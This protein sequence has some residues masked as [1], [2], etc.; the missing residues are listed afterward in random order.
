MGLKEM[1]EQTGMSQKEAAAFFGFKYRT[2]QNYENGETSPTMED[3]AKFAR[4]FHCTIGE[5][6]NLEEGVRPA[7]T[8]D[9]TDLLDAYRSLNYD[10]QRHALAVLRALAGCGEYT[11]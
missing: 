9:E 11:D 3:A 2:Y 4:Y 5:L 10:G 1:R 8:T 6:F 7:L